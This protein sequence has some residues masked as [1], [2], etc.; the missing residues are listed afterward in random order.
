MDAPN[1]PPAPAPALSPRER[2]V[3][4]L[5]AKGHTGKQI[6]VQLHITARTVEHHIARACTRLGAKNLTHAVAKG[7]AMG[8][9]QP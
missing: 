5:A 9:I 6:G 3:L 1:P 2:E 8:L 4:E 7:L